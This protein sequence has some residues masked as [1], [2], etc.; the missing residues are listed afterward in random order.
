MCFV[1]PIVILLYSF[2]PQALSDL[3]VS[4]TVNV[5]RIVRVEAILDANQAPMMECVE[6]LQSTVRATIYR[7]IIGMAQNIVTFP[8]IDHVG[9]KVD[10]NLFSRL[11]VVNCDSLIYCV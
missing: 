11:L 10:E 2:S 4:S 1:G 7:S 9:R 5:P 6:S 8:N 3:T